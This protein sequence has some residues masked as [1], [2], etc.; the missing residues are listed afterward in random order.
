MVETVGDKLA[1]TWTHQ[2]L[3]IRGGAGEAQCRD[4][5]TRHGVA[6]PK[7]MRSYFN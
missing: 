2:G 5:E 3:A 7:D 6:L 1:S 4:F